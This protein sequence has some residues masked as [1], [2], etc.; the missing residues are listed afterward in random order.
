[1]FAYIYNKQIKNKESGA[2]S[3]VHRLFAIKSPKCELIMS[4]LKAVFHYMHDMR[5][6]DNKPNSKNV[7]MAG[8]AV[9][10]DCTIIIVL[11]KVKLPSIISETMKKFDIRPV[12]QL[13]TTF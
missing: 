9:V 3:V 6:S 12:S 1:M 11:I 4:N 7:D 5:M 13:L 2:I 10:K 8:G